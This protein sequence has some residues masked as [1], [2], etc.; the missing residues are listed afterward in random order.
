MS[1][2]A[3][4]FRACPAAIATFAAIPNSPNALFCSWKGLAMAIDPVCFAT[5]LVYNPPHPQRKKENKA[6]NQ[7]SYNKT[8]SNGASRL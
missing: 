5:S 1:Q 3:S 8:T 4:V 7:S 6:T 2:I